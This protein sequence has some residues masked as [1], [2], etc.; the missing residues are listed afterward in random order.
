MII[1]Q[2]REEALFAEGPAKEKIRLL[3]ELMASK[4]AKA[5]IKNIPAPDDDDDGEGEDED[6]EGEEDEE[7]LLEE[8]EKKSH[9]EEDYKNINDEIKDYEVSEVPSSQQG[10]INSSS[11]RRRR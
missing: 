7:D 10:K 3:E 5:Q 2:L 9:E 8:E 4:K 11:F 6:G 1:E